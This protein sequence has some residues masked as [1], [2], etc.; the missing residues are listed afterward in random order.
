MVS[1]KRSLIACRTSGS[2]SLKVNESTNRTNLSST[3]SIREFACLAQFKNVLPD[4][5]ILGIFF[6]IVDAQRIE[7]CRPDRIDGLYLRMS[8]RPAAFGVDLLPFFTGG[9]AREKQ[10]GVRMGRV[11]E[12]RRGIHRADAFAQQEI[13]RRAFLHPSGELMGKAGH[14]QFGLAAGQKLG[15]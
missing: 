15:E 10:S 14:A 1:M 6:D 2:I 8:R 9:P 5:F 11:F 7:S 12:D 4:F 3:A 13:H